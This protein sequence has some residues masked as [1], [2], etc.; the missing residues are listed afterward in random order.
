MERE[1]KMETQTAALLGDGFLGLVPLVG[2]SVPVRM[3]E[4]EPEKEGEKRQLSRQTG[5]YRYIK[6]LRW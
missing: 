2:V 1:V 5:C 4:E 6:K 3:A